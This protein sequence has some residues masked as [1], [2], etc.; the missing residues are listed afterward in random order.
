MKNRIKKMGE[1]KHIAL[2][3]NQTK[4]RILWA[5]KRNKLLVHVVKSIFRDKGFVIV[6]FFDRNVIVLFSKLTSL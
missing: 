4:K 5:T 6:M 2:D 3:N 1:Q